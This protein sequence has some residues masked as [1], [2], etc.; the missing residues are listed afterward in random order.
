MYI[1]LGCA[2]TKMQLIETRLMHSIFYGGQMYPI[3]L[4]A[5]NGVT[6]LMFLRVKYQDIAH[7]SHGIESHV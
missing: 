5:E 2:R 3:Q 1:F 7:H 6:V 4:P